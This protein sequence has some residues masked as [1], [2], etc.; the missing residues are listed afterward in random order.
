MHASTGWLAIGICACAA[1]AGPV[2][3][4]GSGA[5][6]RY[7]DAPCAAGEPTVQWAA[8]DTNA[9]ATRPPAVRPPAVRRKAPRSVPGRSV[10]IPLQADP[11]ACSR[12][13]SAR[14]NALQRRSRRESYVEQRQWDD[15]LRDACR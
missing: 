14:K 5:T 15:R 6:V 2:H 9:P 13:Q 4:C 3:R 12:A 1:L 10:L 11:Q 7:Q 8:P